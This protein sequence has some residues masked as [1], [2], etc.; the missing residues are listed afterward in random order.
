VIV[1]RIDA[2]QNRELLNLLQIDALPTLQVYKNKQTTWTN[3]GLTTK[4][5]IVKAL[6][7]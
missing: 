7:K 3:V 5:E 2:D 6:N 4:E 1:V